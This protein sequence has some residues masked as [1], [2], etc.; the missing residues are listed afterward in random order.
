MDTIIAFGTAMHSARGRDSDGSHPHTGN[1]RDAPVGTGASR[2]EAQTR[3][4]L[5]TGKSAWDSTGY[6]ARHAA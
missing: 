5:T 1:Q 4:A 2:R 3:P 6:R